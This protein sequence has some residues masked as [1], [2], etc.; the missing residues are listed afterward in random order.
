M[1]IPPVAFQQAVDIELLRAIMFQMLILIM[2]FLN[3]IS[4]SPLVFEEEFPEQSNNDRVDVNHHH[5]VK[6]QLGEVAYQLNQLLGV[7]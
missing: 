3:C 6:R 4:G 1:I 7:C 2:C 5:R